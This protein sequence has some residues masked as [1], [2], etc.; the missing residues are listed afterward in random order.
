M[1]G[2]DLLAAN[3]ETDID[4]RTNAPR[5]RFNF[6][7]GWTGSLALLMMRPNGMDAMLASVAAWPTGNMSHDVIVRGPAEAFP[8]E[9]MAWLDDVRC[10]EPMP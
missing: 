8:D 6:R 1:A 4:P 5:I 10:W 2:M 3:F 9:A 7:N